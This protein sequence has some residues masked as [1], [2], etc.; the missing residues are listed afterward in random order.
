MVAESTHGPTVSKNVTQ[1]EHSAMRIL[2][3][4]EQ[5]TSNIRKSMPADLIYLLRNSGSSGLYIQY[6]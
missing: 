3:S 5:C 2:V 6:I 4:T 1:E